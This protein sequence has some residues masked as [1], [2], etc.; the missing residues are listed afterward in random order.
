[1]KTKIVILIDAL[2]FAIAERN[3]F[4]PSCL[5]AKARLRT[6][7]GFSQAALASIFTGLTPDRHGLWMMYSFAERESPFAWLSLIPRSVSERRLWLRRL[8]R[9]KLAAVDSVRG[10]YSLYDVPR[11]VFPYLD[12]PARGDI[13]APRGAKGIPTVFD[14]FE[15][16]RVPSLVWDYRTEEALAFDELHE[17][18]RGGKA[19]FYLLYTAALDSDLHRYGTEAPRIGEHLAWYRDRIERVAA[20]ARSVEEADI[21]VFGDHGMCDVK[22]YVDI[23]RGV[24]ALGLGIG[25]DYVPF[26]DSTMARFRIRSSRARNALGK[27]LSEQGGGRVMSPSEMAELGVAFPDGRFGDIVFLA[28]PG[29]V[30]RPSFMGSEPIAGMHGYD[31][32]EDRMYSIILSNLALPAPEMSICDVARLICPGI[33]SGSAGEAP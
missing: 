20:S 31:P 33:R 10:Y 27:L 17:A 8:I 28:D 11:E 19:A 26:Y 16:N 13:F 9:W 32:A 14:W 15:E 23:M 5:P 7:L 29:V 21:L 12:I 25:R 6:V 24:E 3:G 1:M 18:V 22:S 2:G 30:I 4:A